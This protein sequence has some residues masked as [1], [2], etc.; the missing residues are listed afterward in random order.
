MCKTVTEEI[1]TSVAVAEQLGWGGG[2]GASI[3]HVYCT[4]YYNTVQYTSKMVPIIGRASHSS[5]FRK[6]NREEGETE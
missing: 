6:Q 5:Y 1:E 4:I 3:S 2:G